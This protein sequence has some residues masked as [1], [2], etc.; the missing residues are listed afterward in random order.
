LNKN[1][2]DRQNKLLK[3]VYTAIS[4]GADAF[5]QAEYRIC[6]MFVVCF[7]VVIFVLIS[8]FC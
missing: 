4:V 5:L 2:R 8:F 3:E 7:A 6:G 1:H